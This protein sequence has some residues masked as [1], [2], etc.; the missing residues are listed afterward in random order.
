MME[1]N[2]YDELERELTA[3]GP[4]PVSPEL[5]QRIAGALNSQVVARPW[6]SGGRAWFSGAAMGGIVAAG[7]MVALVLLNGPSR[8]PERESPFV[9]S[10]VS[11]AAGLDEGLPTVWTYRR[12]LDRAPGELEALLDKHAATNSA[13]GGQRSTQL[14]IGLDTEHL[15]KGE[16]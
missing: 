16:L 8:K 14:Y 13:R 6:L 3:I 5:K 10:E 15:F 7:L 11:A 12:A 4:R 1:N 2:D 9:A